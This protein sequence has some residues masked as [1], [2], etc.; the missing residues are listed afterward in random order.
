[1][2]GRDRFN[3]SFAESIPYFDFSEYESHI[4]EAMEAQLDCW[5]AA[6][7]PGGGKNEGTFGFFRACLASFAKHRQWLES[8][9]HPDNA[10]RC[11]TF[12]SEEIPNKFPMG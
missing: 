2:N 5:I 1:V 3:L 12:W 10:I 11:S 7:M 8:T 6:R 9:V 4:K